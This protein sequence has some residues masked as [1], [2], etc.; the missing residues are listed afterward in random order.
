MKNYLENIKALALNKQFLYLMVVLL[1]AVISVMF[2]YYDWPS[3]YLVAIVWITTVITLLWIGNRSI[4]KFLDGKISWLKQTSKR[5]FLQLLLSIA[6]SL[7]CINLT[8]YLFKIT[9]SETAP[10]VEQLLVLNIY[11]LLFI[12]PVLSL[13]FGAYFITQWK[14]EY[15]Q[16]NHLKEESLNSRLEV[17]RMHIDPHFLFNNLNVLSA[18]IEQKPA[19]AQQFLDKFVDVYR[20]VL[21]YKKEQ[22]VNIHTE[23]TFIDSYVFLLKRRF[24]EQCKIDIAIDPNLPKNRAIPPLAL[25]MLVENAVKHNKLS[26]KLPLTIQIFTSGND[27]IV[28]RNNYQPKEQSGILLTQ[29]GLDNIKKRYQYLSDQEVQVKQDEQYFTVSLPLLEMEED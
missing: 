11:G 14:K 12:I 10:D 15:I 7:F 19:T 6:Y 29:T 26:A 9:A 16:S 2:I 22:L 25:Q 13:N 4:F 23:L 21:Q 20:Y 3:V 28:V 8:Y 27:W 18:L 5:F 17:L 24:E 1:I